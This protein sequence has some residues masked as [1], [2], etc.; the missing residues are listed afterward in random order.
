MNTAAPSAIGLRLAAMAI[1]L[2]SSAAMPLAAADLPP[3]GPDDL[4]FSV[5]NM[6]VG[7][8][9]GA[10]FQRYASGSWL[11]RV[12][13][14]ERLASYGVFDIVGERLKAQM[15]LVLLQAGAHVATAPEGSP[16]RQVGA[17]YNAYMDTAA[18]D[19][20]GM[21]PLRPQLDAIAAV[22]SLDD[23]TRLMGSPGE[24]GRAPPSGRLR[25]D[26]GPGRQ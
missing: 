10:N 23:L 22:Q 17:F 8:D 9:P 18:R 3:P 1:A 19:A 2:L 12:Q 13:R 16:A 25:A 5:E 20:A 15:K 14:P 7:V 26:G 6:D 11:D 21:T 4:A 24:H